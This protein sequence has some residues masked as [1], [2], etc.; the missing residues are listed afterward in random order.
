[1]AGVSVLGCATG[2]STGTTTGGFGVVTGGTTGSCEGVSAGGTVSSG[3]TGGPMTTVSP[4]GGVSVDVSS[5][6]I[7]GWEA[8]SM[9]RRNPAQTMNQ[10]LSRRRRYTVPKD[11]PP[12]T[13]V[14]G[15]DDG[16]DTVR[17]ERKQVNI[18]DF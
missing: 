1:M 4:A 17:C 5:L 14:P 2:V 9:H 15:G 7:A 3:T 8:I 6:A 16:R 12:F 13:C 10:R 18:A 11:E